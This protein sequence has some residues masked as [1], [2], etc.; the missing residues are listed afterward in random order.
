MKMPPGTQIW[1]LNGLIAIRWM[2]ELKT[3]LSGYS[4]KNAQIV[5]KAD[6]LT[7]LHLKTRILRTIWPPYESKSDAN[8]KQLLIPTG[9]QAN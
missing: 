5:S 4:V 6:K 7:V 9:N 2:L 1:V 3:H 8:P